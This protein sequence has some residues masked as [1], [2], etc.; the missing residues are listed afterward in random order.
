M[1]KLL[2]NKQLFQFL[3]YLFS[4]FSKRQY[5]NNTT[6][7]LTTMA[8]NITLKICDQN[9]IQTYNLVEKWKAL[10]PYSDD[11]IISSNNSENGLAEIHIKCPL[12]NTGDIEA[13]HRLMNY[14]RELIKK[15]DGNLFVLNSQVY[16]EN[17][18]CKLLITKKK[19][20][21]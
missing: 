11:F 14:D 12:K 21:V 10:M 16:P 9:Q 7:I 5:F 19:H 4:F 1:K 6:R 2:K 8:A 3:L 20:Q 13:C 18:Y 17:N 15:F